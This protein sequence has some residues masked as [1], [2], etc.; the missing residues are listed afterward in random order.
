MQSPSNF[1]ARLGSRSLLENLQEPSAETVTVLPLM[2]MT[3][4][5]D[6]GMQLDLTGPSPPDFLLINTSQPSADTAGMRV[7][8]AKAKRD[9]NCIL[10]LIFVMFFFSWWELLLLTHIFGF[11]VVNIHR[12]TIISEK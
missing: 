5:P 1:I 10:F 4:E 11:Q 7:R 3:F 8:A 12:M 2:T 9:L 6:L